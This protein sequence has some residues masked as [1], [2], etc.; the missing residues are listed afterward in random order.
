MPW[1]L[2]ALGPLPPNV[3]KKHRPVTR[4]VYRRTAG[5]C[6]IITDVG[7]TD[8]GL[9][10]FGLDARVYHALRAYDFA[11]ARRREADLDQRWTAKKSKGDAPE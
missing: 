2:R 7:L 6:R 11:L 9:R 1:S 4:R 8:V 5:Y 10:V 3:A